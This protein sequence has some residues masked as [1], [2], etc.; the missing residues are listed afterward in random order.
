VESVRAALA[1]GTWWPSETTTSRKAIWALTL[2]ATVAVTIAAVRAP[3]DYRALGNYGYLGVFLITLLGTGAIAFPMPYLSAII[4]GGTFLE[5]GVVALVAGVAAGIGELTAY[6][7]GYSGRSLLPSDGWY[8]S[9]ERQVK[10]YGAWV[11]FGASIIPNPF[12][13]AIG[14]IAGATRLPVPV[15]VLA[16]FLGKTI[17][18]WLLATYGGK[19][20]GL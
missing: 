1:Q 9:V 12:F 17:R 18:F 10:K 2:V 14:L 15:F 5:P 4:I 13:D 8:A 7:I 16:C 3:V 11:V 6:L 20:F 19:L